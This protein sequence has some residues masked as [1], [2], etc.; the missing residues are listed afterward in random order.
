METNPFFSSILSVPKDQESTVEHK[1]VPKQD[2]F[3][4]LH[5]IPE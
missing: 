2:E 4:L 1:K 5:L 3:S